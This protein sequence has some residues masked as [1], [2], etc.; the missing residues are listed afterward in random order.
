ML[1]TLLFLDKC[2]HGFTSQHP[3]WV[4]CSPL[5]SARYVGCAYSIASV[6]LLLL[7]CLLSFWLTSPQVQNL[8]WKEGPFSPVYELLC[9]SYVISVS[10]LKVIPYCTFFLIKS[11]EAVLPP[12]S[13]VNL[14]PST[15]WTKPVFL[16]FSLAPN[17][18]YSMDKYLQDNVR[19][20]SIFRSMLLIQTHFPESF[21]N[22]LIL[23]SWYWFKS[24][25]YKKH[26]VGQSLEVWPSACKDG[27]DWVSFYSLHRSSAH[28]PWGLQGPQ[29][30]VPNVDQVLREA[31]ITQYQRSCHGEN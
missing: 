23:I 27:T 13:T 11:S 29:Q 24:S 19:W 2:V 16:K 3:L 25:S 26:L 28:Q 4:Y 14:N 18:L 1:S 5:S 20:E 7:I 6:S 12:Q 17:W 15:F 8:R 21:N 31:G 9:S 22:C 30:L 10:R